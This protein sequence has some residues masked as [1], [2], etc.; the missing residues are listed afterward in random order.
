MKN[1]GI[2]VTSPETKCNDKLCPFHGNLSVRTRTI[3]GKVVSAKMEGT[4][5]VQR[6]YVHYI[7]KYMRYERKR[8]KIPAHNPACIN[9]KEGDIVK[10]AECRPLSKTVSFVVVHKSSKGES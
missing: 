5:I 4:V 3:K 7:K 8:S 6:D 1:I 10:I 9:A 2:P